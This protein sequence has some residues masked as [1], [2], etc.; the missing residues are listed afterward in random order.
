MTDFLAR[1]IKRS[2]LMQLLAQKPELS[3][4]D[5]PESGVD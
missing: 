5:E 4:L 1:E 2:E 3:L